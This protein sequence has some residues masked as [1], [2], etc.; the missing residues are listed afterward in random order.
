MIGLRH[1]LFQAGRTEKLVPDIA[2]NSRG[3][4]GPHGTGSAIEDHLL[5]N[6]RK[7]PANKTGALANVCPMGG[8]YKKSEANCLYLTILVP[9]DTHWGG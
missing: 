6:A 1:P 9:R 7:A 5:S 3:L 4:S 8:G 2:R